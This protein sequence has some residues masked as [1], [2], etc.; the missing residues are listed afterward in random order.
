MGQAGG[1]AGLHLAPSRRRAILG[2]ARL[3]PT[4]ARRG[5]R[6]PGRARARAARPLPRSGRRC[7]QERGLDGQ[8][9]DPGGV[10]RRCGCKLGGQGAIAL[11]AVRF[12]LRWSGASQAV[13]V[14]RRYAD[15]HLRDRDL[16][17]DMA[18]GDDRGRSTAQGCRPVQQPAREAAGAVQGDLPGGRLRPLRQRRGQR[19]GSPDGEVP[20]GYRGPGRDRTQVCAHRQDRPI[21][22]VGSFISNNSAPIL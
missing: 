1:G 4:H 15:Q 9:G 20:G 13:R 10:S 12:R 18:G 14:Q 2:R 19:R 21:I 7:G 3:L 22:F 8:A 17:V 5:G 16:S 6:G 11:R